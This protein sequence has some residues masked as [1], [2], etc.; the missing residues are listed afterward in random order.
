MKHAR[1]LLFVL[2]PARSF[3]QPSGRFVVRTSAPRRPL[4]GQDISKVVPSKALPRPLL[5]K[6]GGPRAAFFRRNGWLS[7]FPA[8]QSAHHA[9]EEGAGAAAAIM[10]ATAAATVVAG[11]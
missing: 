11:V 7:V 5:A 4:C 6:K 8:K 9:T 3:R 2:F 10:T 1:A